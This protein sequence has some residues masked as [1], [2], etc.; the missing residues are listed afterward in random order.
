MDPNAAQILLACR[1]LPFSG[2]VREILPFDKAAKCQDR[3][4]VLFCSDIS[5]DLRNGLACVT[6]GHLLDETKHTAFLDAVFTPEADP[7]TP[8]FPYSAP[9]S[10]EFA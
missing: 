8:L 4:R 7:P 10:V 9:R 6:L 5:N 1:V 3:L 2:V